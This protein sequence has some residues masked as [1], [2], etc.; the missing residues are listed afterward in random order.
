ML[1]L[2]KKHRYYVGDDQ[3]Q[4]LS[5]QAPKTPF[6]ITIKLYRCRQ[7]SVKVY[8]EFSHL[9]IMLGAHSDTGSKCLPHLPPTLLKIKGPTGICGLQCTSE[10]GSKCTCPGVSHQTFSNRTQ[11]NTNHSIGFGNQTKSDSQ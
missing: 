1:V 2:C 10:W 5:M 8:V 3:I 4:A 11:S 7:V 6:V 9:H